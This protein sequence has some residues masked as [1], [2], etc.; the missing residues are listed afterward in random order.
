[1]VAK[2]VRPC[3]V[4]HRPPDPP[5]PLS[6][7]NRRTTSFTRGRFATSSGH[8]PDWSCSSI[9]H[10]WCPILPLQRA[11][12]GTPTPCGAGVDA[13]PTATVCWKTSR[14]GALSPV[15]PPLDHAG[16]QA[17][18]CEVVYE[19]ARPVSRQALAA[20]AARA[21]RALGTPISRRTVWRRLHADARK[22][23]RYGYGM[24]PRDPPLAEQAAVVLDL[25][26]GL[27]DGH[28]LGPRDHMVRADEQ[29]S[30][31]ARIR[32]HP[33]LGPAPGRHRRVA[34]EDDRGGA[35]PYL[36]AWDVGRGDVMGRCEPST[37]L[38]PLGRWVTQVMAREPYRSA[39]RV[40]W[41]VD[42]G[43]SHRG[44]AAIRRLVQAYPNA[45]WVHT[46]VPASWLHP[47]ERSLSLVQ[48]KV[49]TPHDVASLA[50]VE[51]RLRRYEDL[52]NRRP[53]PFQWTF[54]RENLRQVLDRLEARRA[55]QSHTPTAPA[56]S[57]HVA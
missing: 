26:A 30:I 9:T 35:R 39:E 27:W 4:L 48:R 11:W 2:G 52:C 38:E 49:L 45:I 10:H 44:Q 3:G 7:W 5:C 43:A 18:A 57:R 56:H 46:P 24:C 32:C 14:D 8:V 37:G 19:T 41:V 53:R 21:C 36:A 12:L 47:V 40:W 55:A 33:R 54:T 6:S 13:G 51:P 34:C 25:D 50:E 22:P 28:R 15:C 23:W 42:N 29:T 31:H 16:V 1:V 17:I 20:L